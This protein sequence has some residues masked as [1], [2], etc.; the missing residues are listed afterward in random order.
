MTQSYLLRRGSKNLRLRSSF[1]SHSQQ[2]LFPETL[3][4]LI[5]VP[6]MSCTV[7]EIQT[8]CLNTWASPFIYFVTAL[9]ILLQFQKPIHCSRSGERERFNIIESILPI[10]WHNWDV[11]H[12]GLQRQPEL[13]THPVE[14]STLTSTNALRCNHRSRTLKIMILHSFK[15]NLQDATLYN[16]LYCCQCFACSRRFSAHHQELK[17]YI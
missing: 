7:L 9:Y 4:G 2:W 5:S 3:T 6:E 11:L 17:L 8:K 16:I 12:S 13:P 15:Y 10:P 14:V 1:D